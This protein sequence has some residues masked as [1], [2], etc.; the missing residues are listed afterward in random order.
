MFLTAASISL[1]TAKEKEEGLK[2]LPPEEQGKPSI[3]D[4]MYWDWLNSLILAALAIEAFANTVGPEL[5]KH[6]EKFDSAAPLG[7]LALIAEKQKITCEFGE[8][9]WQ[10]LY[11]LIKLRN[12]LAHAKPQKIVEYHTSITDLI[13]CDPKSEIEK[14]ITRQ[15]AERGLSEVQKITKAI[16]NTLNEETRYKVAFDGGQGGTI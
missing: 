16:I 15:F 9:P 6:W 11:D 14:T 12:K 7:K 5:F 3:H 2:N 4:G 8:E 10:T 13:Y 1:K